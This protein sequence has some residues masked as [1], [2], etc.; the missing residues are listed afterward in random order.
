MIR[1]LTALLALLASASAL[2]AQDLPGNP[3]AE[4][5]RALGKS[6]LKDGPPPKESP[7]A[8]KSDGTRRVVATYVKQLGD[9]DAQRKALEEAIL[10]VLENY[11]K[12]TL[13][14]GARPDAANALAFSVAL[15]YAVAKE[16]DLDDEARAALLGKLQASFDVP[17][18]RGAS[19]AQKQEH[20]EWSMCSAATLLSMAA[21]AETAEAKAGLKKLAR[22]Q[23]LAMIGADVDRLTMRGKEVTLKGT[24]GALVEGFTFTAPQGWTSD[25]VWHVRKKQDSNSDS[26]S[27]AHVRFPPSIEAARDAG[28]ALRDLWK[29]AVPAELAGRHSGMVYRRYVGDGL[30]AFFI[31]GAGREKNR[32]SDSL[33]TLYLLD[34]GDR[35]Q[36]VVVAQT[37]DDPHSFSETIIG[38]MASLSYAGT[39]ALAEEILATLRCPA[40][41]G[42]P[43]VSKEALVGNYGYGSSANLQWENIYTGATSMTVVSYGG[44]LDLKADGTFD[45][46]FQGASGQVGALKF[47][48]DKDQGT[49]DVKGDQV[50]LTSKNGKERVHRFAGLTSFSDGVKVAVLISRKDVTPNGVNMGD[51]SD[52]YSTK[53]N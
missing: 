34:L 23:I 48:T 1:T 30:P 7:T 49:W 10:K 2:E 41:K 19:D 37:Y 5:A 6:G 32:K 24:G 4:A 53:K 21:L 22:V 38:M 14:D 27:T 51:R 47:A 44:T 45:Y 13:V 28:V 50:I 9:D 8:F 26:Y 15:H 42:R 17:A 31:F 16:A 18:V 29:E 25:Q 12:L 40:A 39:A 35:W 52:W 20:Y 33:F 46:S 3:V 36:P 43:L 11:E